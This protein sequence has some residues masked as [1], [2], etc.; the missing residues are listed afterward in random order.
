MPNQI[1]PSDMHI[2]VHKDVGSSFSGK[3][4][5]LVVGTKQ[6][7]YVATPPVEYYVVCQ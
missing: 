5:V 4:N 3:V 1:C 6:N 2:L 7:K